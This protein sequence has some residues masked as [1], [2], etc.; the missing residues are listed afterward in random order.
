MSKK[1]NETDLEYK[2]RMAYIRASGYGPTTMHTLEEWLH[3]RAYVANNREHCLKAVGAD[4][5]FKN[6]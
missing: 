6:V 2:K 1:N 3:A 5:M 4:R